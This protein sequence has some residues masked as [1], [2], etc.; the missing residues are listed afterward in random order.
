M[1]IK[2]TKGEKDFLLDWLVDDLHIE[3]EKR[4]DQDESSPTARKYLPI[5]IKKLEKG[6]LAKWNKEKQIYE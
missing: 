1:D 5:I 3:L 4:R 6:S 2:L